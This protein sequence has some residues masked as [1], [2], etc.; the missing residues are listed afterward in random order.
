ML[1]VCLFDLSCSGSR[2]NDNLWK[3]LG[4]IVV[5]GAPREVPW[6]LN[7]VPR[8]YIEGP[9]RDF[10]LAN[11]RPHPRPDPISSLGTPLSTLG[12]LPRG[13]IHHYTPSAFPQIVPIGVTYGVMV[14]IRVASERSRSD[15]KINSKHI[16]PSDDPSKWIPEGILI[17]SARRP[18]SRLVFLTRSCI[19]KRS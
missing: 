6:V 1:F 3:S 11:P 19:I 4:A 5:N 13:S 8:E 7:G 18:A 12:N 9:S 10:L 15:Q 16:P 14:G 2:K 17:W